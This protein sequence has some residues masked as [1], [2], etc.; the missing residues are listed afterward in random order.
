MIE[1]YNYPLSP[2]GEKVRFALAEKGLVWTDRVIDLERKENLTPDFLR[3]SPKALVPVLVSDGIIIV[4]STI[5]NE[6][7]DDR[8]PEPSL[9][10]RSAQERAAMRQWTKYVDEVLHPAWPGIAWPILVRPSWLK[11][12]PVEVDRMLAAVPDVA[13]RERQRALYRDGLSAPAASYSI[14]IFC[15]CCN[16]MENKLNA[17][18][19]LAGASFSLADLA[20]FPYYFAADI[21]G[22][23]ATFTTGRPRIAEW[24]ERIS[25]RP[26]F[27]GD[28]RLLFDP[29]RLANVAACA[30]EVMANCEH[31]N[32]ATSCKAMQ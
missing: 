18:P 6:F 4:E 32:S 14:D 2:C 10:P 22:L 7:I 13:R 31:P 19:W 5:I 27:G 12:T 20:L 11:K 30:R 23:K 15:D 24:Y 16:M 26:A 28:P 29:A 8:W 1:V 9:R 3:L 21:F 25:A 17:A